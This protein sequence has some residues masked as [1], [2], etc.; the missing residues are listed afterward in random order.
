VSTPI[1]LRNGVYLDRSDI[2]RKDESPYYL[3][4]NVKGTTFHISDRFAAF[5][6]GLRQPWQRLS[7]QDIEQF[8]TF[9]DQNNLRAGQ[10][11]RPVKTPWYQT[12]MSLNMTVC[13]PHEFLTETKRYWEWLFSTTGLLFALVLIAAALFIMSGNYQQALGYFDN[14]ETSWIW[15][16]ASLFLTK[17]VHEI[18]H[19]M[20]IIKYRGYASAIK[21]VFVAGL[22]LPKS[23][24]LN[25]HK[26]HYRHRAVIGAAGIYLEIVLA[27]LAALLWMMVDDSGM[28]VGLHF[29]FAVSLPMTITIN[30]LPLMKFDGYY[31]LSGLLKNPRLYE[32]AI[33]QFRYFFYV[34]V[35]GLNC[36]DPIYRVNEQKGMLL[37]LYG[38]SI[39]V[40]KILLPIGIAYAI[41]QLVDARAMYLLAVVPFIAMWWIP[42]KGEITTIKESFKTIARSTSKHLRWTLIV[43]IL[44]VLMSWLYFPL[45]H[46][47]KIKGAYLRDHVS[48][49]SPIDGVVTNSAI[50]GS[51]EQGQ[52]LAVVTPIRTDESLAAS[53]VD[54][55]AAVNATIDQSLQYIDA[56]SLEQ[57]SQYRLASALNQRNR[58]LL[59]APSAGNWNPAPL[60][61]TVMQGDLLGTF[62]LT[63]GRFYAFMPVDEIDE[64]SLD[65]VV[66]TKERQL[67]SIQLYKRSD[68]VMNGTLYPEYVG[69]GE[70]SYQVFSSDV[71][72]AEL[73]GSVQIYY[74]RNYSIFQELFWRL[75]TRFYGI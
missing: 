41:A 48:I 59:N 16:F 6:A 49:L 36:S 54:H 42:L 9:L 26:I 46:I 44:V 68:A 45:G 52:N 73:G 21:F 51:Y 66:V 70:G 47:E 11:I 50:N 56:F 39:V 7:Q 69:L 17:A 30:L 33:S 57:R 10:A 64:N 58:G 23:D 3:V 25:V 43:L 18:G 2:N 29:V 40:W 27:C 31:I 60:K 72:D 38:A 63:T 67:L 1:R 12:L 13:Y 28:R 62:F 37:T 4:D 55:L 74:L 14:Y 61:S 5:L 24:A 65:V 20:A 34:Y 71:I 19:C 53:K 75:Q 8:G 35:L 32:D 22:I 15:V